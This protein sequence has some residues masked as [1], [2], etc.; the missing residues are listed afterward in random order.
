MEPISKSKGY[1][2]NPQIFGRKYG[3]LFLHNFL[4]AMIT[5][6]NKA[7]KYLDIL[8]KRR[9]SMLPFHNAKH[10]INV[11]ENVINISA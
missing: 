4:E 7:K 5:L 2:I 8:Q 9:C 1:V 10:T 3:A 6:V 11:C